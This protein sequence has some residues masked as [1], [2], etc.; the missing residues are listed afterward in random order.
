MKRTADVLLRKDRVRKSVNITEPDKPEIVRAVMEKWQGIIDLIAKILNVPSALIM[1]ITEDSMKVY[2]KSRNKENP[3]E[4]G[5]SDTLGH[6]LYCETV[7]GTNEELLIDNALKYDDW[8]DNPDVELD[9]ISYYGLPLQ[10][11]DKDFFGTICVLDNKE[12]AYNDDFK[13]LIA[14]F[15]SSI[16]KDLDLM[17]QRQKLRFYA[18]MDSLT[19]VYNR[20]KIESIISN[21]Y[22]RS[23]RKSPAFSIALFDLNK[24]KEINDTDGHVVGDAILKAFAAGIN[25]RIRSIDSFGR[26]GG[27]EFILICPD[28]D[29]AG[30]EILLDNVK[31]SVK[32]D[33]D[34]ITPN[35]GFCYGIAEFSV[36][37]RNYDEILKRADKELYAIKT[38]C[39][40]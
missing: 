13:E 18:E 6:G 5:G 26:W 8:R 15:K 24:F 22:A 31:H 38:G 1:Q 7:I 27:D 2:A 3:Y 34:K 11:P 37:D 4:V 9:M 29:K 21:E 33:M 30:M 12:N 35:G 25:S 10:W 32:K 23:M 19:E 17:C 28:T 16:E 36:T 14:A 39:G 40:T 20:R